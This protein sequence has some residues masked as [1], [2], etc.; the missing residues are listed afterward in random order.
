[1]LGVEPNQV[2]GEL[3]LWLIEKSGKQGRREALVVTQ[4][5]LVGRGGTQVFDL[6]TGKRLVQS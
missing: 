4:L 5:R 6:A 1:M 2:E 3:L